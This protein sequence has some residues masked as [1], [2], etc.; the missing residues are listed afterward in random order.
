[1]SN[2]QD[3]PRQEAPRP[4]LS[5]PETTKAGR[6]PLLES[7]KTCVNACNGTLATFERGQACGVNS[8]RDVRS[9]NRLRA[10]DNSSDIASRGVVLRFEKGEDCRGN[11]G[12]VGRSRCVWADLW[13]R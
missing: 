10:T 7:I 11:D 1:M 6:D 2:S 4:D 12:D 5:A 9:K 13:I 3:T 8:S